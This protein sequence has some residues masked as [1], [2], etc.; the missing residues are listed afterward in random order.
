MSAVST[1]SASNSGKGSAGGTQNFILTANASKGRNKL[2]NGGKI[3]AVK[4]NA[5]QICKPTSSLS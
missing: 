3:I 2:P 1:G 4:L 5:A